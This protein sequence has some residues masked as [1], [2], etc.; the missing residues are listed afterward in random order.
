MKSDGDQFFC[1]NCGEYLENG[2]AQVHLLEDFEGVEKGF[3]V[4]AC[5]WCARALIDESVATVWPPTR[6]QGQGDVEK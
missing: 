6:T 2:K 3:V 5:K 4:N 1:I